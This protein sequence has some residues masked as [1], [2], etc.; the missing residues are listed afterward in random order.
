MGGSQ[1]RLTDIYLD[2][3]VCQMVKG[4]LGRGGAVGG[5]SAGAA[6]MSPVMIS[7]GR[8]SPRTARGFGLLPGTLID[9]HFLTRQRDGRMRKAL[10]FQPGLVGLGID[11]ETAII[12][13]DNGINVAGNSKVVVYLSSGDGDVGVFGVLASG[14]K[15]NLTNLSAATRGSRRADNAPLTSL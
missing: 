12:V 11:E 15:V 9:M 8:E 10:Q 4:V 1:T 5:E 2:T 3:R 13:R 7:G 6:I 14:Q